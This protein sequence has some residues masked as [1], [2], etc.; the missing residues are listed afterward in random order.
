MN[1][2]NSVF[3]HGVTHRRQVSGCIWGSK[4]WNVIVSLPKP[5]VPITDRQEDVREERRLL[6]GYAGARVVL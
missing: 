6:H 1:Y 2:K 4:N 5:E 3:P